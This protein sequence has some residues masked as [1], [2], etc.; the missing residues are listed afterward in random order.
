MNGAMLPVFHAKSDLSSL[1]EGCT[2]LVHVNAETGVISQ[3]NTV[4]AISQ[5]IHIADK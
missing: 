5:Q 4:Q 2:R 3:T 1:L